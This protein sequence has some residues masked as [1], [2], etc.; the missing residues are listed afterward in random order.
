V[1]VAQHGAALGN[2]IWSRPGTCIA[3]INID[4]GNSMERLAHC[5][6]LRYVRVSQSGLHGDADLDGLAAIRGALREAV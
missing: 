5:M 1:I 6:E 3:E 2:L 4:T